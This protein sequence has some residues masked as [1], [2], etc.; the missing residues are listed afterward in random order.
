[1]GNGI[2]TPLSN[3]QVKK[4]AE[5]LHEWVRSC[6]E[7]GSMP[8]VLICVDPVDTKRLQIFRQKD[9]PEDALKEFIGM[10]NAAMQ[11]AV[12]PINNPDN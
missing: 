1:M 4:V 8:L 11:G 3:L 12:P 7:T 6:A 2:Y 5:Q 10:V 9:V